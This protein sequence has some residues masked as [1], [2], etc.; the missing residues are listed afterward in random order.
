[1]FATVRFQGRYWRST[2]CRIRG[3]GGISLLLAALWAYHWGPEQA[4]AEPGRIELGITVA[5]SMDTHAGER[6]FAENTYKQGWSAGVGLRYGLSGAWSLQAEILH[7]TRG[8]NVESEGEVFDEYNFRYVQIPLL[9]RYARP[10]PGMIGDDGRPLLTGY[11]MAGPAPSIL[12]RAEDLDDDRVLPRSAVRD[13]DVTVTV[14]LGVTW[15]FSPRWAASLEARFD[16]GFI[17][18]FSTGVDSNNQSVLLALGIGYT[19]NDSDGDGVANSRDQCRTEAEDWNDYQDADGCPDDDNDKDGV[20]V[21]ADRCVEDPEDRDGFEDA[22]G[23]PDRDNDGDGFLDE[24]DGC[25]TEPF[26]RMRGCPPRFERVRIEGDR[27]VLDP[28]LD[29]DVNSAVLGAAQKQALD[30][31]AELL[32]DYYPKMWLRLEGHADG[33]G[34]KEANQKLS[35]DRARTVAD[36]L[37]QRGINRDRLVEKGYGEDRPIRREEAEAGKRRNRRVELVIIEK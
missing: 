32:T 30:Q 16:R 31:V 17:D 7:A 33:E 25:P 23:C 2:T 14:G 24:A 35:D 11:L 5:P 15:Q 26:P 29:F 27:L 1:M 18:A 4:R 21:A 9:A 3:S 13:F 12:L 19:L 20:A 37:V 34:K 22:D 8:T 28:V 6:Q 10:I 36:Y